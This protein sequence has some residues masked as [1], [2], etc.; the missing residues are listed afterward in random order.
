MQLGVDGHRRSAGIP[1]AIKRDQIVRAVLHKQGDPIAG[2]HPLRQQPPR[3]CGGF[4]MEALIIGHQILPQVKRRT[5]A[6]CL[7]LPI[8]PLRDIHRLISS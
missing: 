2:L 7:R 5:V 3:K 6:L 1:N 4:V 8:Q